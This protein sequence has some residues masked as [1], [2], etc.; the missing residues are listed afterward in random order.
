[1]TSS[2]IGF[3]EVLTAPTVITHISYSLHTLSLKVHTLA[4]ELLAA[5]C[6]LS[7]NEGHKAV[8]A[9]LSD[10]RVVHEESFR[11]ETII[12]TLR[13]PD[14][15]LESEAEAGSGFGNEEEGVWEARTASM[16]LIN[17][18]TNCPESLDERIMLRD[19]FSRR[20]LNEI[21]VVS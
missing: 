5:I 14:F 16:A 4:A 20:G 8:L 17:A 2:K 9:A 7:L 19:E 13:L 3:N 10:F 21:I 11:F 18:I 1:M 6:I 15:D 12:S